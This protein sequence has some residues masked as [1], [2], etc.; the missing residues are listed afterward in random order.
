M[1]DISK[2]L[3]LF[4]ETSA[5][6]ISMQ[7]IGGVTNARLKAEGRDRVRELTIIMNKM[8]EREGIPE[9]WK[10]NMYCHI[11]MRE[12]GMKWYVAKG[13]YRGVKLLKHERR[14]YEGVLKQRLRKLSELVRK[15]LFM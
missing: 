7:I 10:R 15:I 5:I 8:F 6:K 13:K 4:L 14:V 1:S 2:T 9:D 12:K 3:K 11:Y